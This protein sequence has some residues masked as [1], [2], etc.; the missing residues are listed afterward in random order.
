MP[1][2]DREQVFHEIN[3][4]GAQ[5]IA[6]ID[7]LSNEELNR[8]PFEGSWTV[9]QVV[10]HIIKSNSGMAKSM[11]APSQNTDRDP[12]ENVPNF[13]KTFLN[14][15]NR[16]NAPDFIIPEDR[17]YDKKQLREDLI[18]SIQRLEQSADGENLDGLIEGMPFG[19][20]T[21][22]EILHFVIYH[23]QRHIHQLQK[24]CGALGK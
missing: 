23:T 20:S 18:S 24:I 6:L 22:L 19:P 10:R 8:V 7:Q 2:L 13:E 17:Q 1:V 5:L 3:D 11:K 15:E 4:K 21:K 14:R 12:A 16:F 9:G